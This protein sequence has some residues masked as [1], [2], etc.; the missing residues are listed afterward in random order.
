MKVPYKYDCDTREIL[1]VEDLGT[2]TGVTRY[3]DY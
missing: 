3:T 2:R 1:S